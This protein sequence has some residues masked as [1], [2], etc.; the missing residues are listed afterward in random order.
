MSN[1]TFEKSPKKRSLSYSRNTFPMYN[2]WFNDFFKIHNKTFEF[3][4]ENLDNYQKKFDEIFFE[5]LNQPKNQSKFMFEIKKEFMTIADE[6][7]L[8]EILIEQYRKTQYSFIVGPLQK[9]LEFFAE[10]DSRIDID[11]D[12]Y[13]DNNPSY[14]LLEKQPNIQDHNE[15]INIDDDYY[16][17][18]FN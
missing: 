2:I 12:M 6:V 5:W 7:L 16:L 10:D 8:Q 3:I 17:S 14:E 9:Y 13:P 11:I 1:Q 15:E 18:F 4:S